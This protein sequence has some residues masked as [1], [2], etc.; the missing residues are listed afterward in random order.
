MHNIAVM[1]T[2]KLLLIACV[3]GSVS[4]PRPST[5]PRHGTS[6]SWRQPP[7]TSVLRRN[8]AN[9]VQCNLRSKDGHFLKPEAYY[10]GPRYP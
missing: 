1:L 2:S 3:R 4:N 5:S 6:D 10:D 8:L 9:L 7:K